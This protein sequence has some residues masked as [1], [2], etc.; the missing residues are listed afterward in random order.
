M[1]PIQFAKFYYGMFFPFI[2]FHG[3]GLFW[4]LSTPPDL[5]IGG[6]IL[7]IICWVV[8]IALTI[9]VFRYCICPHCKEQF[10]IFI[11]LKSV[12]YCAYCGGCLRE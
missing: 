2:I 5:N 3:I 6:I 12:K 1:S 9:K 8:F 11:I 4:A 10:Q 7:I